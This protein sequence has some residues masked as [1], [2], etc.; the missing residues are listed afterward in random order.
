[1]YHI[2][3]GKGRKKVLLE[4]CRNNVLLTPEPRGCHQ[5]NNGLDD[6]GTQGIAS[7]FEQKRITHRLVI[8]QTTQTFG[9]AT[10][11]SH[12]PL[13]T[14]LRTILPVIFPLYCVARRLNMCAKRA[15]PTKYMRETVLLSSPTE[16]DTLYRHSLRVRV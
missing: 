12:H 3:W 2:L 7:S 5:E 16:N 4:Q 14:R 10:V 9:C 11:F 1:L 13:T 8:T 6:K 15:L